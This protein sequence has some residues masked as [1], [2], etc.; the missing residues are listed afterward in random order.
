MKDYKHGNA[1]K[2][3]FISDQRNVLRR[4]TSHYR[5]SVPNITSA[6]LVVI[7]Y[8]RNWLMTSYLAS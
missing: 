7:S 2:F 4:Y 3:G 6:I 8:S 1:A 5:S